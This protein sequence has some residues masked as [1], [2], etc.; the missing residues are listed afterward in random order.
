MQRL[1]F[2]IC[3]LTSEVDASFLVGAVMGVACLLASALVF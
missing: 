3:R 1:T 2:D